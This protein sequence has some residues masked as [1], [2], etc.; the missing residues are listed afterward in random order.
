[1]RKSNATRDF[2]SWAVSFVKWNMLCP[3]QTVGTMLGQ[4]DAWTERLRLSAKQNIEP[5]HIDIWVRGCLCPI[6]GTA[7]ARERLYL[8]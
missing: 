1:M 5:G 4:K 3:K 7:A 6:W 2:L 8:H